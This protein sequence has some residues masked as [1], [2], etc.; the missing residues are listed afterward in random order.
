MS[1]SE[2]LAAGNHTT[3]RE[4]LAKLALSKEV[5]VRERVAENP[6]CPTVALIALVEDEHPDVRSNVAGNPKAT[7][8]ML[9]LLAKDFCL[10]V[11]YTLAED[12]NLPRPLL[13]MLSRDENPYVSLRAKQTLDRLKEEK[14]AKRKAAFTERKQAS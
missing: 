5:K 13:R 12:H 14:S 2:Y 4:D 11:R 7:F 10:N 9:R 3:P 8:A 1:H 6:S